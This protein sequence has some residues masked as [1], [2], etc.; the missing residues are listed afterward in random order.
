MKKIA[1][2]FILTLS[3]LMIFFCSKENGK[4]IIKEIKKDE[5]SNGKVGILK[6]KIKDRRYSR[7][8]MK[9]TVRVDFSKLEEK[10]MIYSPNK[11]LL[12]TKGNLYIIDFF[13]GQYV[14]HKFIPVSK[15]YDKFNHVLF[16]PPKGLGPEDV[17]RMLDVKMFNDKLYISDDGTQSIKVFNLNGKFLKTIVVFTNGKK[18]FGYFSFL[19]NS[20]IVENYYY[21]GDEEK[22]ALC[23]VEGK[24]IKTFGS[25]IDKKHK[26]NRIYHDNYLSQGFEDNEYYYLPCYLGFVTKYKND[27]VIFTKETIDGLQDVI[28]IK[29]ETKF[30]PLR[31][32]IKKIYTVLD[33][34]IFGDYILIKSYNYKDKKSIWDIY[35]LN[36]FDYLLTI[37]DKPYSYV[38]GIYKNH[39]ISACEKEL[40]IYDISDLLKELKS[41][42]E[43]G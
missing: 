7:N 23:D 5:M 26:D 31:K 17:S 9:K 12:D 14:F 30:G 39:L 43:K 40:V 6:Q 33:Y 27:K 11:L 13:S 41:Y 37:S 22:F 1:P 16:S 25:D 21:Y 15:S 42:A 4:D 34:Y 38:V 32:I 28:V 10:K 29:K 3:F 8:K 19:K 18:Y 24:S 2:V 20:L 35:T 36:N